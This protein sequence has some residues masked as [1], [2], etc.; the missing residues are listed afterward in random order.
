MWLA[1][2]HGWSCLHQACEKGRLDVVE[3]LCE[4]G[5]EALLM[6][7]DKVCVCHLSCTDYRLLA[8]C[9]TILLVQWINY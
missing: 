8:F 3:Y 4:R 6:L 2:Q 7:Q 9:Q 1:E 5:G